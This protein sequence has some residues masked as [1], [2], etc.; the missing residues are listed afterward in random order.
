M[1]N[2]SALQN[3]VLDRVADDYEA[4]HTIASDIARDL[5]K[6]VSE[7]EVKQA[8]L[9]LA[10]SGAVQAYVYDASAQRYRT[11]SPAEAEAA[12]EAWFMAVKAPKAKNAGDAT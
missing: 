1:A 12:K 3:E 8:L 4:A 2:S 9:A 6:A 7:T 5:G 10:H 11:V